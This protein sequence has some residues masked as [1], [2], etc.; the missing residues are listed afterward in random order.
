MRGHPELKAR[1]TMRA[2][3]TV[4]AKA[5]WPCGQHTRQPDLKKGDRFTVISRRWLD[6]EP[7]LTLRDDAGNVRQYPEALFGNDA[8]AFAAA[9]MD[10]WTQ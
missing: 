1:R 2:V 4:T 10:Q 5:D 6:G 8:E 9:L 3:E 7:V